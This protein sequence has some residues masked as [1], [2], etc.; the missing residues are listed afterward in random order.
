MVARANRNAIAK[1][2]STMIAAM[3]A[4]STVGSI[5]LFAVG[6]VLVSFV[7][8]LVTKE[9]IREIG[10]LK[11]IGA[12]DTEVVGQFLAEV[13]ALTL[14]GAALALPLAYLART[15]LLA[16]VYRLFGARIGRDVHLGTDRLAAFDRE[17]G[18]IRLDLE[19]RG[20]LSSKASE[21]L[22]K[23]LADKMQRA[24]GML[25]KVRAA[26]P[27]AAYRMKPKMEEAVMDLG[28]AA[29]RA[30]LKLHPR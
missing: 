13:F 25:G 28:Q 3:A 26:S 7:M 9:R 8:M 15:P 29:D 12:A 30:E 27:A 14:M 5:V 16:A 11:A 21:D 24:R 10:T 1:T 6:G 19:K 22:L 20:E 2:M 18:N 23:S 4:T 17:I